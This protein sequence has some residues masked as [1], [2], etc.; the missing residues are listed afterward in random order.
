MEFGGRGC[1]G[2]KSGERVEEWRR[3]CVYALWQTIIFLTLC[4][5]NAHSHLTHSHSYSLT[6][7]LTLTSL[8]SI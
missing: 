4:L 1:R 7:T 2:G 3:E 8:S 6:L 5:R